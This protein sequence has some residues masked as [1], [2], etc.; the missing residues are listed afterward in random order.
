MTLSESTVELRPCPFC[1][2]PTP[3]AV[4][5]DGDP[6]AYAIGCP[7]CGATGPKGHRELAHA[8]HAWNQ[9]FGEV[10]ELLIECSTS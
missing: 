6:P 10:L 8:V 2:H 7:E 1:A 9:R 4:M 5:I 3:V